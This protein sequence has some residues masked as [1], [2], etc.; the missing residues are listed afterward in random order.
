MF[1]VSKMLAVSYFTSAVKLNVG[2]YDGSLA[3]T[4][5]G[6]SSIKDIANKGQDKVLDAS[7]DATVSLA[8]AQAT[9]ENKANSAIDQTSQVADQV[10]AGTNSTNVAIKSNAD[11]LNEKVG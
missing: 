10:S 6:W 9:V 11:K 2:Q 3:Q 1:R 5:F 8:S 7:T 4:Q